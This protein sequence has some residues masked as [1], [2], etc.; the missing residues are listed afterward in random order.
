MAGWCTVQTSKSPQNP[1]KP[2]RSPETTA[3]RGSTR[4]Q[5]AGLALEE[6][7]HTMRVPRS[8]RGGEVVEPLV[9]EQWF[10]RM[11]PLA[12]PALQ[13][14]PSLSW[15]AVSLAHHTAMYGALSCATVLWCSALC[16]PHA[17]R[18]QD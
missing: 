7:P 2:Y 6:R 15:T 10:V 9:R 4:A 18:P 16:P 13:A 11:Q 8:Q 12:Q 17:A 14:P 3:R 1:K 5:A